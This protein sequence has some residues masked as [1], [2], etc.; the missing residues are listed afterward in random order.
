MIDSL[1]TAYFWASDNAGTG[2]HVSGFNLYYSSGV[3]ID[4][5]PSMPQSKGTT[6]EYSFLWGD[7]AALASGN[8]NASN[9]AEATDGA[10][11]TSVALSGVSARYIGIEITSLHGAGSRMAIAQVEFTT[12]AASI[13]EPSVALIRGLGM[14]MLL[15]RSQR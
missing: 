14:L 13:P 15:R 1:D 11:D 4:T 5:H 6:G 8:M 7:C 2:E 12:S 3:G 9:N 10:L